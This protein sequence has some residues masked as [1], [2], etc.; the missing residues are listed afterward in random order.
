MIDTH[1][2]VLGLT[3][4]TFCNL[5]APFLSILDVLDRKKGGKK[6][7]QQLKQPASSFGFEQGGVREYAWS[8]G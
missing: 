2:I 8:R 7:T 1:W 5:Q 3:G 4:L 6:V